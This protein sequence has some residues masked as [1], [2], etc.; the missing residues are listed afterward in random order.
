MLLLDCLKTSKFLWSSLILKRE[1]GLRKEELKDE[2]R[3]TIAVSKERQ[4]LP[5]ATGKLAIH[6]GSSSDF[7]KK[8]ELPKSEVIVPEKKEI[9]VQTSFDIERSQADASI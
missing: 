3:D 4:A 9:S 1:S 2:I 8:D 6:S 7:N 5:K